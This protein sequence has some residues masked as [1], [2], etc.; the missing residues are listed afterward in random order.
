MES[1]VLFTVDVRRTGL[2]V[3]LP[4][5]HRPCVQAC[6]CSCAES[7]YGPSVS[8][9][10]VDSK[11]PSARPNRSGWTGHVGSFVQLFCETAEPEITDLPA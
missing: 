2:A 9:F 8:D 7:I 6:S 5:C 11:F 10:H 4:L 3:Y 1:F